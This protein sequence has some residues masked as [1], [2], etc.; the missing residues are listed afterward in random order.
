VAIESHQLHLIILSAQTKTM[1]VPDDET[2]DTSTRAC[3]RASWGLTGITMIDYA[4]VISYLQQQPR[5]MPI[6]LSQDRF[7]PWLSGEAGLE[8]F[9]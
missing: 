3:A 6:L 1:L 4:V 7:E 9:V 5:R 2:Y 8:V